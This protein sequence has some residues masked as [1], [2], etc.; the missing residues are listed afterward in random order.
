MNEINS[1]DMSFGDRF[2]ELAYFYEAI[3]DSLEILQKC[4][5]AENRDNEVAKQAS[6]LIS[7]LLINGRE[8][9]AKFDKLLEDFAGL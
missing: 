9:I 3:V 8:N 1:E 6:A 4:L 7:I 2:T 5:D